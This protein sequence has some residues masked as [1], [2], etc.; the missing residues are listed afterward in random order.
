MNDTIKDRLIAELTAAVGHLTTEN[1]Y[2]KLVNDELAKQYK[3]ST[4]TAN[5][6]MEAAE[7]FQPQVAQVQPE[8]AQPE[9]AA[10]ADA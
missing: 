10:P 9:A 7:Q 5:V 8:A 2:L 4:N 6:G 1:L 3:A